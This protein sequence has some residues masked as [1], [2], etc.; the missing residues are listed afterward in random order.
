MIIFGEKKNKPVI[1]MTIH[2]R[3]EEWFASVLYLLYVL[4]SIDKD[5]VKIF[6]DNIHICHLTDFKI[7]AI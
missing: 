5:I 3:R 1:W 4:Q 2:R 7:I 6:L